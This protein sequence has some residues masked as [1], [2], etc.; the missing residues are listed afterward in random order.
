MA[1]GG[2]P[3]KPETEQQMALA[4]G[5]CLWSVII[6]AGGDVQGFQQVVGPN[7]LGTVARRLHLNAWSRD[8]DL[9]TRDGAVAAALQAFRLWTR[10]NPERPYTFRMWIDAQNGVVCGMALRTVLT[11]LRRVDPSGSRSRQQTPVCK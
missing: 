3:Q 8:P 10:D 7:L 5:R 11:E 6:Q 1:D 4:F 9:K 2:Y